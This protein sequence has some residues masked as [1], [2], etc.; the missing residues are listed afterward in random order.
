MNSGTPPKRFSHNFAGA[1][2][3]SFHANHHRKHL[4]IA[5]E[6]LHSVCKGIQVTMKDF[7]DTRPILEEVDGPIVAVLI[8][9]E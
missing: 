2:V 6:R 5:A 3:Q 4:V 1:P 8:E 9:P 7:G